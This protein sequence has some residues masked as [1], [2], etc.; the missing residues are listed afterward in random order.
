MSRLTVSIILFAWIILCLAG[1]NLPRKSP[2]PPPLSPEPPL[3]TQTAIVETFI[4]TEPPEL[5]TDTPSPA[6]DFDPL[7]LECIVGTWEVDSSS[8]VYAANMLIGSDSFTIVN[9][10]PHLFFRFLWDEPLLGSTYTMEVWYLDVAMTGVFT[11]GDEEH[12][13]EMVF[14]GSTTAYYSAGS[15]SGEFEYTKDAERSNMAVSGLKIDGIALEGG[16]FSLD[17]IIRATPNGT[18]HYACEAYDMIAL[19]DS[20]AA[21]FITLRRVDDTALPSTP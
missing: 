15:S 14:N 17:D 5:P 3:P 16:G 13:L 2:T 1:C 11:A 10:S 8:L 9:V 20:T 18:M 4:P 6:G 12:L 19:R 7:E 21:E